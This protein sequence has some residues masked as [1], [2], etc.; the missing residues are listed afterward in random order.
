MDYG[1]VDEV[2]GD[3]VKFLDKKFLAEPPQAIRGCL[4]NV[5]PRSGLWAREAAHFFISSVGDLE[6]YA[7]VTGV[8]LNVRRIYSEMTFFA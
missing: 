4:D 5:I 1:T 3:Q 6:L 8:D 7:R 2:T